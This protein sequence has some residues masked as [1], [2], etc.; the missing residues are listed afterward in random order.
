MGNED[1]YKNKDC[2]ECH[3]GAGKQHGIFNAQKTLADNKSVYR[4]ANQ[5]CDT[6]RN[7][8]AVNTYLNQMNEKVKVAAKEG[9]QPEIP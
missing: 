6:G 5:T 3:K 8:A 9:P 1:I 2:A 7:V 4:K